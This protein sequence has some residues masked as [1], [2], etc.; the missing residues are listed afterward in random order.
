LGRALKYYIEIDEI[1]VTDNLI[2]QTI[3]AFLH[4]IIFEVLFALE[5]TKV[6]STF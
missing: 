3:M 1:K 4:K 6:W 2:L 5:C